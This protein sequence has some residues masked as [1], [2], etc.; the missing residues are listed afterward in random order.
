[1]RGDLAQFYPGYSL[2]QV[3][4]GEL[5]PHVLVNLVEQL[6][7]IPTS[8]V[9]AIELGGIEFLGWDT[10]QYTRANHY[11]LL[12]A[13]IAGLSNKPLPDDA[14]YPRPTAES[15]QSVTTE[16]GTIADFDEVG[17]MRLIAQ[18]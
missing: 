2:E 15:E 8:R 3:Y 12:A 6:K 11:D 7:L 13:L 17:F 14:R 16:L 9:R 5:A 1:V 4:S 10:A 18:Q